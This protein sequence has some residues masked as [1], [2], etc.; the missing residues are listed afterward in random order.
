MQGAARHEIIDFAQARASMLASQVRTSDV[1]DLRL[2]HALG[3]LAREEFVSADKRSL[4]Y[5]DMQVEALK[6]RLLLRPRELAKLIQGIELRGGE[7][8]LEIAGGTGY[9]AAI[10]AWMGAQAALWDDRPDAPDAARNAWIAAGLAGS[11]KVHNTDL[12]MALGEKVDVIIVSGAVEF[13][14]QG[15]FDALLEG[16]RLGVIVREGALGRARLYT[17]SGGVTAFRTLF[18]ASPVVLEGFTKKPEFTF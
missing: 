10:L 7:T 11:I 18:D 4:A 12:H 6:G 13:V 2:Q 5:A 15:W 3:S 16:G 9:G 14:P 8:A 17:K 1:T